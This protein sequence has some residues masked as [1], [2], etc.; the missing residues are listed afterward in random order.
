MHALNYSNYQQREA[1]W[2]AVV[3][4]QLLTPRPPEL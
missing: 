2:C 4:D 3:A 1:A